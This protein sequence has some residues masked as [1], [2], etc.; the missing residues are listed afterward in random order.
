MQIVVFYT[1]EASGRICRGVRHRGSR[2]DSRQSTGKQETVVDES[3]GWG[4]VE[5]EDKGR[6]AKMGRYRNPRTKHRTCSSIQ[7]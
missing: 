7:L 1:R 3:L 2:H 6:G 5:L 4:Q